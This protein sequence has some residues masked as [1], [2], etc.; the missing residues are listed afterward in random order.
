M[1]LIFDCVVWATASVVKLR[2]YKSTKARSS[3][4]SVCSTNF[5]SRCPGHLSP[6]WCLR[7]AGSFR[8]WRE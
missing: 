8:F 3:C 2:I 7:E 6:E 1:S 4:T 5:S